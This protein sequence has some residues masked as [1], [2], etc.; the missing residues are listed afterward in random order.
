MRLISSYWR[1][2]SEVEPAVTDFKPQI[3][4]NICFLNVLE[5]NL[6][7]RFLIVNVLFDDMKRIGCDFNSF[8]QTPKTTDPKSHCSLVFRFKS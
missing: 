7:I 6:K 4:F 5:M 2:D 3:V 1:K 8:K